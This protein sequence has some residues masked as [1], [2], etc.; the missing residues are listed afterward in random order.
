MPLPWTH[1]HLAVVTPAS[2]RVGLWVPSRGGGLLAWLPLLLCGSPGRGTDPP[3]WGSPACRAAFEGP[4]P[5]GSLC[6]AGGPFDEKSSP[7]FMLMR[8]FS[9]GL[10]PAGS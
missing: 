4:L 7:G 8:A 1:W 3:R 5:A 2:V 10:S 9:M 6:P